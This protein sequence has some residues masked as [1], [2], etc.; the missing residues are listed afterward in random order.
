MND[1]E[2]GLERLSLEDLRAL[3]K[4]LPK[5]IERVER[6]QRR[7]A[8]D[9]IE[10]KA[11]EVGLSKADLRSRYGGSVSAT[12]PPKPTTVFRHP[13]TGDEWAGRGR[14]PQ[15]LNE[16]EAKGGDLSSIEIRSES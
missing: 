12:K 11:A 8:F 3:E 13:D 5:Q 4:E 7:M 2:F 1:T 16:F 15:W 9:E 6:E 14:R 10:K